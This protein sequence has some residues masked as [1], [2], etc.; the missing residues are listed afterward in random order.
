MTN[1]NSNFGEL[2][3]ATLRHR[4]KKI[5]DA[6][7]KNNALY[8]RLRQ[9]KHLELVDGGTVISS[10]ID[11]DENQNFDFYTG[12]R[13]IAIAPQA[14]FDSAEVAWK[15]WGI[16]VTMTGTEL[17]KNS[18]ENAVYG[19]LAAKTKNAE[20][21]LANKLAQA[22]YSDGTGSNGLELTGMQAWVSDAAGT[23]VGN[24]NAGNFAFWEC[25]R[26]ATGGFTKANAYSNMLKLYLD[27]SRHS[28]QPDL[29]VADNTYFQAF[30]ES[31]HAQQRFMD[32]SMAEAGF[33]NNLLFQ[34]AP[35]VYDGGLGGFAP[36]G[37]YF[38]NCD[39]LKFCIHRKRNNVVLDGPSRA[40]DQDTTS[41]IIAGMG[42]ILCTNRQLNGRL[43]T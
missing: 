27:C 7:T 21:S 38:L 2:A 9:N 14:V 34:N 20:R 31:L 26:L 32:R 15:Q 41:K 19:L 25:Q 10:P 12:S 11:Y 6:I 17:M 36:A 23:T 8:Y 33:R 29:I 3:T 35:V 39:T 24:I 13:R 4:R 42:N 22:A 40:V 16:G 37:M 1:P 30:S 28:D 43:T 5:A 18:G